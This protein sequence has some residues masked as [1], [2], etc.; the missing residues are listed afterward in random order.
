MRCLVVDVHEASAL[1]SLI[2]R[3]LRLDAQKLLVI[4]AL[5]RSD[6]LNNRSNK[7]LCSYAAF[8]AGSQAFQM[9]ARTCSA[10]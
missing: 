3:K 7:L 6:P 5:S 10:G 8:C 9:R 2:Y 1:R 4:L